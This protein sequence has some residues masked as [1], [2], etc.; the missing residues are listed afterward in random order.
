[1]RRVFM[2]MAAT[3]ALAVWGAS[4]ANA[5]STWAI[6]ATPSPAGATESYLQ[7]VSCVSAASCTAVGYYRSSAGAL[8]TLAEHRDGVG[9][10]IQATPNP[11]GTNVGPV[12]LGAVSCASAT[13]CTAVGHYA[14]PA[15][16]A[17]FPLA[18]HWD[19]TAWAIQA[20]PARATPH[21]PPSEVCRAARPL[22]VSRSGS[23]RTARGP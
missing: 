9:W 17:G 15:G 14:S 5:A 6:Q 3:T 2:I 21:I 18:E 7:G 23:T 16:N 19:G 22:V 12:Y 20:T 10:A 13:S 11:V 1:M 8:L 4:V